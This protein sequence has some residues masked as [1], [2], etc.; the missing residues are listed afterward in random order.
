MK[1]KT[2]SQFDE[3]QIKTATIEADNLGFDE[4]FADWKSHIETGKG[5][6]AY[7]IANTW[8]VAG[9]LFGKRIMK[10]IY[11]EGNKRLQGKTFSQSVPSSAINFIPNW[12]QIW[13]ATQA[14]AE[15]NEFVFNGTGWYFS[16]QGTIIVLPLER[17]LVS[18]WHK[19]HTDTETF[20]FCVWNER[21]D[22]I[23]S[24]IAN[25]PTRTE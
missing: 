15:L 4:M 24:S 21:L 17:D 19:K 8:F 1:K 12:S 14:E 2:L 7:N 23:F 25:A 20:L 5:G 6:R 11:E 10:A 3:L 13:T 22:T 16:E 9:I 18:R